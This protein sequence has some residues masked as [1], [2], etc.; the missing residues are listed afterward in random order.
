MAC[1]EPKNVVPKNVYEYSKALRQYIYSSAAWMKIYQYKA[2]NSSL[3]VQLSEC[4][5]T[6][7]LEVSFVGSFAGLHFKHRDASKS[8]PPCGRYRISKSRKST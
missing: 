5:H 2:K 6:P 1:K 3:H 8:S 4:Q 7:Q